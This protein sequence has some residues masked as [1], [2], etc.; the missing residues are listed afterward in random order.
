MI[1]CVPLMVVVAKI[2][3][4]FT[5][6]S[7]GRPSS[8]FDGTFEGSI[9]TY[10][11]PLNKEVKVDFPIPVTWRFDFAASPHLVLAQTSALFK[12]VFDELRVPAFSCD[13]IGII[14][15]VPFRAGV[16]LWTWWDIAWLE[17]RRNSGIAVQEIWIN[18]YG[19]QHRCYW[20]RV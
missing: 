11:F 18:T 5:E 19:S 6:L 2:V 16:Y 9:R 12:L 15:H 8:L 1:G 10:I 7:I 20:I 4:V 13:F 17:L 14:D 3:A